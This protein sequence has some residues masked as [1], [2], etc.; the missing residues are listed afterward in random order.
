MTNC[1]CDSSGGDGELCVLAVHPDWCGRDGGGVG[2]L[3][4]P[5]CSGGFGVHAA[6][7]GRC[8]GALGALAADCD[9][10]SCLPKRYLEPTRMTISLSLRALYS[11]CRALSSCG[12]VRARWGVIRTSYRAAVRFLS[13][14]WACCVDSGGLVVRTRSTRCRRFAFERADGLL[15]IAMDWRCRSLMLRA[16][17]RSRHRSSAGLDSICTSSI[18][19]SGFHLLS[20]RH[21]GEQPRA[22]RLRRAESNSR[23]LSRNPR[24]RLSLFLMAESAAM[25]VVSAIATTVYLAAGISRSSG[26]DEAAGSTPYVL[27]PS[28]V[29]LTM[30]FILYLYFWRAAFRVIATPTMALG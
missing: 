29:V 20:R 23:G 8:R 11:R 12:R 17:S 22:L 19:R 26:A 4:A 30:A 3:Y 5:I 24:M 6:R 7:W 9:A 25:I 14:R 1:C 13:R 16:P 10:S 15:R 2:A 28:R 27:S 18:N 21:R